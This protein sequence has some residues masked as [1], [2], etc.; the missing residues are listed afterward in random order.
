MCLPVIPPTLRS[1]YTGVSFP[2]KGRC[3]LD[4][5]ISHQYR[6]VA[7]T[8]KDPSAPVSVAF[9]DIVDYSCLNGWSC[10]NIAISTQDTAQVESTFGI[11]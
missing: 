5:K 1:K 4:K 8:P 2:E 10:G 11:V 3:S 6:M 9:S 7:T